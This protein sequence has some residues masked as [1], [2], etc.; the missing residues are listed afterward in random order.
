MSL[1][2]SL[3]LSPIISTRRNHALE[4]AT[5]HI[6]SKKG[7]K[8]ALAGNSDPRGFWLIGKIGTQ[9]LQEAVDQAL[10]RLNA[11]EQRLAIHPNCGT[12][13]TLPGIMAGLVGWLAMLGCGGSFRRKL[14]RLP[15]VILLV[16]IAMVLTWPLG[17]KFQRIITT[18]AQMGDL[19]VHEI[20][21]YERNQ[22]TLHRV[23]TR[24]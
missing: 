22:I 1:L 18:Q 24:G 7:L 20:R 2:R 23:H 11:G 9:E 5:L 15:V 17:P 3:I 13:F 21:F 8:H 12:N 19:K 6:L 10:A 4:H 14:G 16:T